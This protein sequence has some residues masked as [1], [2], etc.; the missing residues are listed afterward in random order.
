MKLEQQEIEES[1]S[2]DF[3]TI[4]GGIES[5]N[6]GLALTMVSKNLYSNAIGSFIREITTNAYDANVD[7]NTV[8]P[9]DINIF[10]ED[11]TY[12]I[13]FTDRGKGLD[14][15]TFETIYM[16]WFSSDK[17]GTNKKHGGWGLGSKSP[18]AYQDNFEIITRVNGFEY[19]YILVNKQPQPEATLISKEPFVESSFTH[20]GTTIKIEINKEDLYTVNRECY[21]QLCYFENVYIKNE[22]HYY[23]N[24]FKLYESEHFILRNSS[25]PF[26]DAMHIVL[27]QVPYPIDWLK[28]DIPIVNIPV[29]LKFQIGDLDVTL[30]REAIDYSKDYVI[31]RIKEKIKIV[32]TDLIDRYKKQIVVDDLFK[33]IEYKQNDI[34]VPLKIEDVELRIKNNKFPI[35]LNPYENYIY[36]PFNNT[37]MF[38]IYEVIK[39]SK[40]KHY[41]LKEKSSYEISSIY[42][43]SYKCRYVHE[44]TNYFDS[45]YLSSALLIKKRK[46]TKKI[47]KHYASL[48]G[49]TFEK[50]LNYN[51]TIGYK[52]GAFKEVKRFID[53]VDSCV[54]AKLLSY[55]GSAPEDWIQEQKEKAK[56]KKEKIKG[57]IT[58][59]NADNNRFTVML[60]TLY[61]DK[62]FVFFM[63]NKESAEKKHYYDFLYNLS[64]RY[65]LKQ[66]SF[67][68]L[69][70]TSIN[71][72]SKIK[73]FHHANTLFKFKSYKKMFIHIKLSVLFTKH[74]DN[75]NPDF[76]ESV[77]TYYY[78]FYLKLHKQY[79]TTKYLKYIRY[80]D[81]D[82]GYISKNVHIYD[83]FHKEIN[84]EFNKPN[85][86]YSIYEEY[87][88]LLKKFLIKIDLLNY[89]KLNSIPQ[90]YLRQIVSQLKVLKLNS[91]YYTNG[92]KKANY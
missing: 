24:N 46:L 1:Q 92:S 83:C 8:E 75:V 69:S 82:L 47:Y 48:L 72:V 70:D 56:I 49:L 58:Y 44:S 38:A 5:K 76:L 40:G 55:E 41:K 37:G 35:S 15:N 23:D 63:S 84:L 26:G 51:T 65:F 20:N 81:K 25:R 67:I 32:K 31:D 13:T 90:N 80:K 54:K 11:D 36:F 29:A 77:S 61:E 50:S 19:S 66:T 4:Q 88:V 2:G 14:P 53:Y 9:V 60:H 86:P 73:N 57:E 52:E 18:F 71:K 78:N 16:N 91:K 45:M 59:Y 68:F 6:L 39:L 79:N 87:F 7:N 17:R 85:R 33:Y 74:F 27:G 89:I 28:L 64:N 43:D 22:I 62:K 12:F 30:S 34:K 10:R 42:N 21:N 3:D